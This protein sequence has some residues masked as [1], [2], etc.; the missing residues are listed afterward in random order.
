[1][2][3]NSQLRHWLRLGSPVPFK[4]PAQITHSCLAQLRSLGLAVHVENILDYIVA[5]RFKAEP[6][7]PK[8]VAFKR[9]RCATH[10]SANLLEGQQSPVKT[11]ADDQNPPQQQFRMTPIHPDVGF[12]MPNRL[13][14]AAGT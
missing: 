5:R 3:S 13:Q 7:F 4:K 8:I 10:K 11:V 14:I 9:R 1:M 12:L 2:T 6:H